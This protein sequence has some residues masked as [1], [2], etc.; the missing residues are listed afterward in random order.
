MT[1]NQ[2]LKKKT[3]L[4]VLMCNM[5]QV[6]ELHKTETYNAEKAPLLTQYPFCLPLCALLSWHI[7]CI[8]YGHR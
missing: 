6:L 2:K 5:I 3:Y 8:T 1:S 7:Y 4:C